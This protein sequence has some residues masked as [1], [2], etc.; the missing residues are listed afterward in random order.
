[1]RCT[2]QKR[3]KCPGQTLNFLYLL[4]NVVDENR[5]K[6]YRFRRQH[7]PPEIICGHH[8]C[9]PFRAPTGL[10]RLYPGRCH[11]NPG[12][13][14][15]AL[16]WDIPGFQPG[17]ISGFSLQ[18]KIKRAGTDRTYP[19]RLILT[20]KRAESPI[21]P[22]PGQRPGFFQPGKISGFS[23]QIKIKRAGTDRT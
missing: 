1:M 14:G 13:Q 6:Q 4:Y 19:V 7:R 12:T 16:G 11:R 2:R 8:I 21:Y 9:C 17:K 18:I 5:K 15:V 22:S 23:L 10:F 20:G 3:I